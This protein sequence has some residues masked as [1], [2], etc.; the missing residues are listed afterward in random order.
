MNLFYERVVRHWNSLPRE[1]VAS[2]SPEMFKTHVDVVM[3]DIVY[4][5]FLVVGAQL[6]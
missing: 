1:V 2:P 6:D 5:V 3:R 4:W